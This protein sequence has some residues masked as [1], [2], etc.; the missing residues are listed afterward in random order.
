VQV[1]QGLVYFR[2]ERNLEMKKKTTKKTTKKIKTK[3]W[4]VDISDQIIHEFVSD[5]ELKKWLSSD[6]TSHDVTLDVAKAEG[7]I[8]FTTP[9]KYP[10]LEVKKTL[11]FS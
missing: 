2:K 9:P 3:Y 5:E 6:S 7:I 8:V 10:Y 4:V 1:L 11:K